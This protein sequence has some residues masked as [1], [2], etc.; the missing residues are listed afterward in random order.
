MRE[1]RTYFAT[2]RQVRSQSRGSGR[3]WWPEGGEEAE[4]GVEGGDHASRLID[5]ELAGV[6]GI[7]VRVRLEAVQVEAAE[8]RFDLVDADDDILASGSVLLRGE[9]S[10][11]ER[12]FRVRAEPRIVRR[13]VVWGVL[14]SMYEA[15]HLRWQVHVV[16]PTGRVLARKILE[17]E[18]R[19]A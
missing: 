15:V 3:A 1:Q 12:S 14:L 9:A 16:D 18:M 17:D 4:Q 5:A 8:V 6:L 13:H 10:E 7:L 19:A 2:K 11:A